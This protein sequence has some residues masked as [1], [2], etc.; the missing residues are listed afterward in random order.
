MPNTWLSCFMFL[1]QVG[2]ESCK[3]YGNELS[4]RAWCGAGVALGSAAAAREEREPRGDGVK[5]K[6]PAGCDIALR[7]SRAAERTPPPQP[8]PVAP[9]AAAAGA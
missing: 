4:A 8:P 1:A 7:S 2:R 3:C 6:G 9:P 5:W